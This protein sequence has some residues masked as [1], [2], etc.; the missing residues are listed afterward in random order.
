MI[1]PKCGFMSQSPV[2][3]R[4]A[5]I[6]LP[7]PGLIFWI[8]LAIGAVLGS[9]AEHYDVWLGFGVVVGLT[10]DMSLRRLAE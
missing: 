7:L 1:R 5:K 10:M 4:R 3:R 8:C 6:R 9:Q 2:S